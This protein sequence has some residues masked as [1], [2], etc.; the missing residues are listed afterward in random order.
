MPDFTG[1][2]RKLF[3][4]TLP[5]I[6]RQLKRV[7]D[8][9]ERANN[10]KEKELGIQKQPTGDADKS[11][12]LG[13]E[14]GCEAG[15]SNNKA[16]FCARAAAAARHKNF[17]AAA[18]CRTS[19]PP[20]ECDNWCDLDPTHRFLTGHHDGCPHSPKAI[21]KALELIAALARGMELWG[22]EKD[23]IYPGA[24]EAYRKAK[25][26]QGV[27]ILP[28]DDSMESDSPNDKAHS[29]RVSEAKGVE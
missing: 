20:C 12:P 2:W 23:G 1:G 15:R 29:C 25:A 21:D 19:P 28:A 6:S 9:L 17:A 10:L 16:D 26:L 5:P 22:A 8:Q 4:S 27:F 24:L 7:A 18:G 14:A 3:D 11:P 13:D